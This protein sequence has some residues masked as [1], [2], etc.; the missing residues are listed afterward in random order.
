MPQNWVEMQRYPVRRRAGTRG[1]A[2]LFV[3]L[4]IVP[5]LGVLGLVVDAGWAE[6]RKEAAK[7]AAEAGAIAAAVAAQNATMTCSTG[8]PCQGSTACPS[9]LTNPTNP[10]QAACLYAQQN[11]FTNGANSGRQS[12]TVAANLTS[13]AAPPVAG[14]SPTYWVSVTVTERLPA[15]FGAVL[16]LSWLNTTARGTA[17]VFGTGGAC[18][19]TLEPT[20]TAMTIS[21]GNIH[22]NCGIQIDSSNT[23]ALVMSGGN[24][25]ITGGGTT[26]VVGS[27][28]N[29]GGVINPSWVQGSS[30]ADVFASLP[31]PSTS[32]P[33]VDSGVS[34]STGSHTLSAGKHC[35]SVSL[36]GGTTTLQAGTHIF[37][38][39]LS[40]S[41]GSILDDGAGGVTLYFD[42]GGINMS[43]ANITLN[44]PTSGTYKGILMFYNRTNASDINMSGGSMNFSGAVYAKSAKYNAS[45]GNFNN[46][47]FV[48]NSWNQSGGTLQ[49]NG[50]ANTNYTGVKAQFIE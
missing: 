19:E 50:G 13:N 8:V 44:A 41:G 39:G 40:I 36:S 10:I 30:M 1:Q 16:G 9:S 21:G 18:I 20:Q 11:G 25:Q 32:G 29:S 48:L 28:T 3:T 37:E 38:N 24:I 35:G 45:G 47:T 27:V 14:Y 34:W 12:V 15:T 33:C 43:G 31:A 17:G 23:S 26:T 2:A 6:W 22:T 42:V 7:T 4:S 46:S 49:V 5:T